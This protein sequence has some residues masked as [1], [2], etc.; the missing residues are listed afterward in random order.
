MDE[1]L[2]RAFT[3]Y[4]RNN[5]TNGGD[6]FGHC[7]F[8]C[9]QFLRELLVTKSEYKVQ[10]GAT[11]NEY[12][13]EHYNGETI[14]VK[15]VV[16]LVTFDAYSD[17]LL[18]VKKMNEIHSNISEVDRVKGTVSLTTFYGREFT[19]FNHGYYKDTSNTSF[20]AGCCHVVLLVKNCKQ[21]LYLLDP[22]ISQFEFEP[23]SLI[24]QLA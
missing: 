21:D 6:C 5:V 22:T 11:H 20:G 18:H 24:V 12:I 15:K 13:V 9:T 7:D 16:S 14:V 1:L 4:V 23:K 17:F 2:I 10:Q 19:Y 8:H 3:E